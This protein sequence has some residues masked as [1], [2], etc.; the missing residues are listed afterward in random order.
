M[1]QRRIQRRSTVRTKF[2]QPLSRSIFWLP[3]L[4]PSTDQ[5][6]DN[7][8]DIAMC[9]IP[10]HCETCLNCPPWDLNLIAR[11]RYT[12]TSAVLSRY[13]NHILYL[14]DITFDVLSRIKKKKCRHSANKLK[15]Y[16]RAASFAF[17]GLFRRYWWF[18]FYFL[19][20]FPFIY[21][22]LYFPCDVHFSFLC[23]AITFSVAEFGVKKKRK[24]LIKQRCHVIRKKVWISAE[25]VHLYK[26]KIWRFLSFKSS[27]FLISL[28][29]S[30]LFLPCFFVSFTNS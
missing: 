10:R 13:F 15:R 7:W 26:I 6:V 2:W 28:S 5:I 24:K 18:V 12:H 22:F 16:H 11:S 20:L 30:F 21:L 9:A 8:Y 14:R 17:V 27:I 4:W 23:K 3:R 29:S 25:T 1:R 19:F